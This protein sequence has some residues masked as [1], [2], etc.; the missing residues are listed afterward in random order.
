MGSPE[1]GRSR[2]E[3]KLRPNGAAVLGVAVTPDNSRIV[4]VADTAHK[5]GTQVQV[6]S[7]L[8]LKIPNADMW[9]LAVSADGSR[10]VT[11]SLDRRTRVWDARTG[12]LLL[13]LTL[14]TQGWSRAWR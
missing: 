7:L 5:S 10:I 13:E 8:E 14:G 12:R 4:T 6:E 2:L 3:V 11:G 9:C 1:P